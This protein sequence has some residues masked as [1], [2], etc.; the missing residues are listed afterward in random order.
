MA[1]D[2]VISKMIVWNLIWEPRG[3]RFLLLPSGFFGNERVFNNVRMQSASAH[4]I[5]NWSHK[6]AL[7]TFN[8]F[9]SNSIQRTNQNIDMIKKCIYLPCTSLIS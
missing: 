2:R 9:N 5:E 7:E 6:F 3:L 8:A 1:W 4:C